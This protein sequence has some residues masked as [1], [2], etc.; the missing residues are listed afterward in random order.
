M[1]ILSIHQPSYWPWLGLLDKIA[2][3]NIFILLDDVQVSKGSYQYRNI[4][5]CNNSAKFITI[6]VNLKLGVTFKEL[7]FTNESWKTDHLNKLRN[8]YLKAP[9]FSEVYSELEKFYSKNFE[10]PLDLLIET[11]LFSFEKL[12][13]KVEFLLSSSFNVPGLKAEKVLNLCKAAKADIYIAGRGSREYMRD[14]LSLFEQ[15]NI[16]I[17]WHSFKHPIYEQDKRYP[18]LEG[19]SCLDIFFFQGFKKSKEIFWNNIKNE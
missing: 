12:D 16:K 9:Y 1:K 19:L 5:F 4:F 17:V 3:S 13:I 6:P 10:K 18:F 14:Y 11:M 8:Y 15:N 7:E 2:K